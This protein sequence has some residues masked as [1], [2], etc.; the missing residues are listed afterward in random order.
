MHALFWGYWFIRLRMDRSVAHHQCRTL[1]FPVRRFMYFIAIDLHGFRMSSGI[2]RCYFVD[3]RRDWENC[4][5]AAKLSL[6]CSVSFVGENEYLPPQRPGQRGWWWCRLRPD[7]L[8]GDSTVLRDL[9]AVAESLFCIELLL[10]RRCL[11]YS[12]DRIVCPCN[13]L[14]W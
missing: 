11:E 5:F 1:S 9:R 12:S 14:Q 3:M 10:G 6:F 13:I 7:K 8:W 2:F 4:V